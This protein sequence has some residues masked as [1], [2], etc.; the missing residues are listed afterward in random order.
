MS[1]V[2]EELEKKIDTLIIEVEALKIS[3]QLILEALLP[4][5][6]YNSLK[7]EVVLPTLKKLPKSTKK[8]EPEQLC[9]VYNFM[10]KNAPYTCSK[11]GG[12]I[13]WDLRPERVHPLHVDKEGHILGNGDCPA[14]G[15]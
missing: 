14:W 12:L 6:E 13:S 10:G 11:C 7:E 1:N 3:H 2:F 5:R 15:G 8:L 9:K 4:H